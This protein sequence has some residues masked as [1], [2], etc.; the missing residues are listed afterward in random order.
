[1]RLACTHTSCTFILSPK[2][3]RFC[4]IHMHVLFAKIYGGDFRL[5]IFPTHHNFVCFVTFSN[6]KCIVHYKCTRARALS[7]EMWNGNAEC[8]VPNKK[9]KN[10][11]QAD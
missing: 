11:P 10:Y 1:M 7:I 6:T 3:V 8:Q 5:T 4:F 2:N 9:Q